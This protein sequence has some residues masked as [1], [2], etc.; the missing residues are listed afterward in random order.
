MTSLMTHDSRST[1][2]LFELEYVIRPG[3]S[4]HTF[5]SVLFVC[6]YVLV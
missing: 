2:R 3:C 6:L 4:Y 5:C 1:T